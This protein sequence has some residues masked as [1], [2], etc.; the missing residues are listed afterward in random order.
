MAFQMKKLFY[1]DLIRT[2]HIFNIGFVLLPFPYLLPSCCHLRLPQP[3][4]FLLLLLL[5]LEV[6]VLGC[7]GLIPSYRQWLRPNGLPMRDPKRYQ[8]KI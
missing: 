8:H 5:L 3:P 1:T 2:N 4:S 6:R 7:E